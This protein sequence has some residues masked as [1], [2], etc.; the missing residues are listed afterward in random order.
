MT[1]KRKITVITLQNIRNYGSALQA[2]ATQAIFTKLGLE[3]DFINYLREDISSPTNRVER[4]TEGMSTAKKWAYAL[5]LYPTFWLQ[6]Y[7]FRKF[8]KQYLKVIPQPC[9]RVE[10]FEELKLNSDI[11]CT[12]S[13]QT[14]NSGWNNGLLPPLFLSFVPDGIKKIAYSASFGKAKLD[15][16]EKEE[17]KRLLQRYSAISVRESTGV[18]IIDDL[19]I[20]NAVH[21]LD[22]TLQLD[23]TFWGKYAGTGKSEEKYVLVY[24]L[25]TNSQFDRYAKEYARRKGLKL[26]RLCTRIDQCSKC[27]KAVIVPDVF[28]FVSLIYHA[29]TVITDSFHATAFSINM[30]T[31][32]ISIYPNEFGGRL[33]SILKL[34]GLENR[35]LTSYDDFSFVDAEKIDFVPVNAILEREREIGWNFLRNAIAD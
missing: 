16:W 21:V 30:N 1:K 7:R 13:D 11:Y 19:G 24:Q 23:K 26:V 35:H 15:E 12:G 6:N 5:M 18:S 2:F 28:D 20:G 33:E 10:D 14:W 27:G 25:N 22:P 9:T 31:D 34:V 29:D 3:S 8:I 32:V 17:T 4:W